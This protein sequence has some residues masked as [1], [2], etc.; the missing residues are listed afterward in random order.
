MQFNRQF[1]HE[2]GAKR[3]LFD[4]TYNPKTHYFEVFESGQQEGYLLK[5]DMET[6]AWSTEGPAAPT[7][8]AEDLALLVQKQF[9]HFV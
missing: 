4:V 2:V 1:E 5:F 6:R 8:P 3:I 9:G 7:I